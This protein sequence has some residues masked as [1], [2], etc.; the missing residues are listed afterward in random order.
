MG[1]G[2]F[3]LIACF[4]R[5]WLSNGS[6]SIFTDLFNG[7]LNQ[8]FE[9]CYGK[10]TARYTIT[11]VSDVLIRPVDRTLKI[12]TILVYYDDD[13]VQEFPL[14][15]NLFPAYSWIIYPSNLNKLFFM[16]SNL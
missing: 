2:Y 14:P 4:F 16:S 6:L 1:N 15:D 5:T 8:P 10:D 9:F 12:F 13:K 3:N 11:Y 7:S